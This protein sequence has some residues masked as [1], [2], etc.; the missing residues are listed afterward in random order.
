MNIKE[1][2]AFR[3]EVSDEFFCYV[4]LECRGNRPTSVPYLWY[5]ATPTG[6]EL[7]GDKQIEL[8]KEFLDVQE[9]QALAQ[10]AGSKTVQ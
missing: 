8:E 9:Q 6:F 1:I 3:V 5:Q 2:N 4:R 10:T 7:I